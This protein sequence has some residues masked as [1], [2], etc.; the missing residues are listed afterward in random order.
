MTSKHHAS[1]IVCC[2]YWIQ[3]FRPMGLPACC[4]RSSTDEPAAANEAKAVT[5]EAEA[6]NWVSLLGILAC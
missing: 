3:K 4:C 2:T 1:R 5:N 6:W